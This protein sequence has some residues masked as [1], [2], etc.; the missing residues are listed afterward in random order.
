MWLTRHRELSVGKN[1][2]GNALTL[3]EMFARCTP[4]AVV[5]GPGESTSITSTPAATTPSQTPVK[6]E[7]EELRIFVSEERTWVA[8]V[9]HLPDASRISPFEFALL[10]I[11]ASRKE[12][13]IIQPELAT[14]SGQDKRS[15]PKR[16]DMLQ[17][18]GYIEKKPVQYKSMRT[19]LC[20]LRKFSGHAIVAA[21]HSEDA[22]EV[23]DMEVFLED[24]ISCLRQYKLISRT[25][26]RERLVSQ[27][28]Y[29]LRVLARALRRLEAIGCI[30]RV[31]AF[32]QY[33]RM[34]HRVLS[35]ELLREPT[36]SDRK[37]FLEHTR[38]ITSLA[39]KDDADDVEADEDQGEEVEAGDSRSKQVVKV[40]KRP[41]P[42][43][44]PGVTTLPNLLFKIINE[45][46]TRGMTNMVSFVISQC[47][48]SKANISSRRLSLQ[49][50]GD[51][52]GNQWR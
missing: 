11:I 50:W 35:I 6:Q 29:R 52:S 41:V 10:S 14:V 5:N 42:Q 39:D 7:S 16:T 22:R 27:G 31:K 30:R 19:S 8:I 34:M 2:E 24:I 38:A 4:G 32:S 21:D 25:D 20:I 13:G 44:V 45:S 43:F 28:R 46:G 12:K 26:L 33:T 51:S 3:D 48:Y 23:I 15:V 40:P 37:K 18:R 36:E 47:I 17:T 49:P 9:G 1:R